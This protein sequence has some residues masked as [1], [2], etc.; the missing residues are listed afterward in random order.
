M[1]IF[2][3]YFKNSVLSSFANMSVICQ[4]KHCNNPKRKSSFSS[5]L[6]YYEDEKIRFTTTILE[7]SQK[8]KHY[9]YLCTEF[10]MSLPHFFP[11]CSTTWANKR[12]S[13]HLDVFKIP[14]FVVVCNISKRL[15]RYIIWIVEYYFFHKNRHY[16]VGIFSF[17]SCL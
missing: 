10:Q 13:T 7:I 11:S 1:E 17:S 15:Q 8:K 16:T 6:N 2:L 14:M 5:A 4:E 3:S 9:L 12:R